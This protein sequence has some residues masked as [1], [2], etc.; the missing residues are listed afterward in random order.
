MSSPNRGEVWLVDLGYTAKVRPCLVISI[1][2]VDQD[3]ALATLIPHTTS[4]RSSRFEVKVEVKFLRSGV[5]DVQNLITI[6]HA[7]LLRKLGSLTPEQLVEVEEVLLL[8]LGFEEE[9]AEDEE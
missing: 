2:A 8:W 3:R 1:P 5:F 4:S 6:P 9:T 7:K